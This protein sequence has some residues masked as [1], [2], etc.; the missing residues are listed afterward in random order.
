MNTDHSKESLRELSQRIQSVSTIPTVALQILNAI[1]DPDSSINDLEKLIKLDPSLSSK[2][3]NMANSA[4]FG[5]TSPIYEIKNAL[6]NL[7]FR[8]VTEIALSASVCDSFKSDE[9]IAHYN[10]SGLWEHSVGVALCA[11]LVANAIKAPY[12]EIIFSIGI[13]H[14][15]G[16][17][18]LDQY[19]HEDFMNIL[20]DP[21]AQDYHLV[22]LEKEILGFDHQ[23]LVAEVLKTWKLPEEFKISIS[24]HHLMEN[25][26]CGEIC[27]IIY[28][29][30]VIC[31]KLEIGF[32]ETSSVD[33]DSYL[34]CLE[35]LQITEE[36][37]SVIQDKLKEEIKQADALLQMA[38]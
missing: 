23:E 18:M 29:S 20:S 17:I 30:N 22:Q 28:L 6:I 1:N 27:Q 26:E 38:N 15:L 5:L 10:R 11:K 13:L 34:H 8:T 31:N 2:V 37:I 25:S 24:R 12:E 35:T 32:V 14:D 33:M 9:T 7:G 3:L 4:Y 19:L 21:D 36:D 16:V